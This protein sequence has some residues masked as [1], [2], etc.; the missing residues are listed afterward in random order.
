MKWP[1]SS[2]AIRKHAIELLSGARALTVPV[3]LEKVTQHLNVTVR[4]VPYEGELAGMIMKTSSGIFV[5]VNSLHSR[6][7]QR[8]TIA[9]EVGHLVLHNFDLHID[10][11]F[12]V[13]RR[14]ETSSLAIDP[15]EI[16]ANRFAAELLMPK[17]FVAQDIL[18]REIDFENDDDI[19]VLAR[20]YQVSR[21]AMTLRISNLIRF[22][23]KDLI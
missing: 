22:G 17:E 8:F 21:Q 11:H 13:K 4:Q 12:P 1:R 10:T 15:E 6:S 3:P 18:E 16:E 7:R 19:E 20:R 9:H 2:G 5:G 14:D 23:A